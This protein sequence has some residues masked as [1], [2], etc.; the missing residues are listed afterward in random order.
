MA[1]E[2]FECPN[3]K[4]DMEFDPVT[5]GM[6]CAF[7]GTRTAVAVDPK[8]EI[9]E[10][11]L[12][13]QSL[14]PEPD[15]IRRLSDI[16]K[17]F[18]CTGCGAIVQFEPP[19]VAGACPFCAANIVT[20]PKN[21]DPLIAPDGVLP[22]VVPKGRASSSVREWLASRWFA[23]GAL[24]ALAQPEG[25]RGIYLPFWTFDAKTNTRY[26]G[27]RGDHYFEMVQVQE[28]VNGQNVIREVQ[29]V[30]TAWKGASGSVAVGFDDVLV[31][32][33]RSVPPERLQ[34]LSPWKLS[35]VKPYESAFLSGFQAQRYQ[36]ELKDGFV[37]SRQIMDRAVQDEIRRDI[38]GDEQQIQDSDTRYS[39]LTFKHL[40]LP[41]WVGS[42]RFEG[43]VYQVLV[44]AQTGEVIGDRPYSKGKIFLFVLILLLV[45]MFLRSMAGR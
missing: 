29:Q 10:N 39:N 31:P 26:T 38:G 37:S 3:C 22:F 43:C 17:E 11:P 41:V 27:L 33:S 4:A 18:T 21:S 32:A 20:Q 12:S 40:L 14:T 5:R 16:S 13:S 15:R 36:V 1:I 45:F 9:R 7:C 6:K 25:I 19:Q 24:A 42:Y 34:Q 30:R 2:R 35:D 28:N 8:P 44:N 23:P